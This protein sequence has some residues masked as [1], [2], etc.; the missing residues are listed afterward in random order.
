[1][2]FFH[3]SRGAVIS[4]R[5]GTRSSTVDKPQ[6]ASPIEFNNVPVAGRI[7]THILAF[8]GESKVTFSDGNFS[9]YEDWRRQTLGDAAARPHRI[10][11]Q[12]LTR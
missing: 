12:K 11:H 4:D 9:T 3:C 5:I 10:T 2:A 7:V 8:E 1:M 6:A